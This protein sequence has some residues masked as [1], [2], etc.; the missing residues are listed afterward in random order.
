[1]DLMARCAGWVSTGVVVIALL[2]AC[3]AKG[4]LAHS[5]ARAGSSAATVITTPSASSPSTSARRR[6]TTAAS[7]APEFAVVDVSFVGAQGWA[8]GSTACGAGSRRCAALAHSSDGGRAWTRLP[9]PPAHIFDPAYPNDIDDS[10]CASPCVG[11]VQ[12]ATDT[13]GYLFDGSDITDGT[14]ALFMT[15]DGGRS[16]HRQSGGADAIVASEGS[17]FRVTDSG[18]CPPSCRYYLNS[19]TVA[20]STWTRLRLPGAWGS[21]GGIALVRD[22]ATAA[23]EL[24]GFPAGGGHTAYSTLWSSPNDGTTWNNRHEPCQRD[25]RNGT[26][27]EV[28]SVNFSQAPDGTFAL[29]CMVRRG[30]RALSVATS[31]DHGATFTL[32]RM[33]ELLT[34][35]QRV[36]AFAT[37]SRHTELISIAQF[38]RGMHG[39][40]Y[41]STDS[42]RTF[43]KV[44]GPLKS[45]TF[46]TST[47]GYGITT[48]ER[49]I[50]L[51][52]NG[53]RTWHTNAIA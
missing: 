44:A 51:T 16:W 12:F 22:H 34:D 19:S 36:W 13:V 4:P 45:I 35:D 32:S 28:D 37:A 10:D 33:H 2:V 38:G 7:G 9:A 20:T 39:T 43:T 41:R 47:R 42:G 8:L 53:G 15:T 26:A 52:T 6:I 17:V 25:T 14:R 31:D 46:D 30:G 1:M 40:T 27:M 29:V 49:A 23:A 5:V 3:D 24:F 18:G 48:D 50:A 21:G 11:R